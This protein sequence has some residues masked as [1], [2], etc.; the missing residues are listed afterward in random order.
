MVRV[1]KAVGECFEREADT[2]MKARSILR[3]LL[4][5]S[6]FI[7]SLGVR[8][9]AQQATGAGT[10]ATPGQPATQA[11]APPSV[12]GSHPTLAD[13]GWLAGRWQ[14]TWGPR[15]AQQT[16]TLPRA[17]VML[18]TFQLAEGDK[19]LVLELFALVEDTSGITLYLRHFTPALTP[20]EKPGPTA[21][22]LETADAKS[23]VFVN[24]VDGEPKQ[25][26]ITRID[27]DTYVS[28]SEI[29]P[30][31]GD[32]QVTEITYHRVSDGTPPKRHGPKSKA[33]Q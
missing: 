21:L 19:T 33:A 11:P 3:L 31:K 9:M 30:D 15:L 18:G 28:R 5:T 29:V 14:G 2:P 27:T 6:L 25:A 16:W 13:F 1:P 8:V 23:I 20:W 24:L 22:R 32:P 12:P 10:S 7:A 26:T 4:A 17:G